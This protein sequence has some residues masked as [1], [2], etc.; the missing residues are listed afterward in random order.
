MDRYVCRWT[1]L[2]KRDAPRQIG[3]PAVVASEQAAKPAQAAAAEEQRRNRGGTR[4]LDR[5]EDLCADQ[6]A[7]HSGDRGR[8]RGLGKSAACRLA[9]EDEHA[10]NG[11]KTDEDAK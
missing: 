7:N 4:E 10:D 2:G 5:P 11:R 8:R 9:L 3:R 1:T 6:A